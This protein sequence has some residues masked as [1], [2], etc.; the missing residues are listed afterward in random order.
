MRGAQ[1]HKG[2]CTAL[3]ASWPTGPF[4]PL[5]RGAC[6]VNGRLSRFSGIARFEEAAEI[7]TTTGQAGRGTWT[8]RAPATLV[9]VVECDRF[10]IG[11]DS[12]G[13]FLVTR[14]ET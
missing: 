14:Y 11:P 13:S 1:G 10:V 6:F 2:F 8:M 5:C 7:L 9:E 12:H 4:S 3:L